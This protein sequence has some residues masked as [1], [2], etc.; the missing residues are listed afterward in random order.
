MPNDAQEKPTPGP[1]QTEAT[2]VKGG[3]TFI[4]IT[5]GNLHSLS[6]EDFFECI[7]DVRCNDVPNDA[8]HFPEAEPKAEAN[9][10]L[11][12]AAPD[13][14][15]A[16]E[17]LT[18]A[19]PPKEDGAASH[20]QAVRASRAAHRAIAKAR[21][22]NDP[23]DSDMPDQDERGTVGPASASEEVA[24]LRDENERLRKIITHR[25]GAEAEALLDEL[26]AAR[27]ENECLRERVA[28]L[29]KACETVLK[30]VTHD[31]KSGLPAPEGTPDAEEAEQILR[32]ALSGEDAS[33]GA[34]V[35][36]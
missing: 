17:A 3:E 5:R 14:L 8:G 29:E 22:S 36:Q 28:E 23:S 33:R 21:G 12:S 15:A 10:H 24:E 32:D 20:R 31:F 7:A 2:H 34:E 27:I 16:C 13:L 18:K 19:V 30:W 25:G 26:D 35:G 6:G 11:I 4:P 9:A 1:W